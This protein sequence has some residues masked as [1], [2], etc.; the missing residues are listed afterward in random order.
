MYKNRADVI[1]NRL[2]VTFKGKM[3]LDEIKIACANAHQ[4]ARRLRAGFGVISDVSEFFPATEDGRLAMQQTMKTLNEMGMGEVVR[5]VPSNAQ[6][7]GNQWQRTSR[8]V[9][10]VAHQVPTLAEAEKLLDNLEKK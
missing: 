6:V 1:K 10:Y 9:G 8:A 4:E 2:Y 7:A 3:E 5:I